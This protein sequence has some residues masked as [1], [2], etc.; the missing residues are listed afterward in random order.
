MGKSFTVD[1]ILAR[2]DGIYAGIK[3]QSG[4]GLPWPRDAFAAAIE[5]CGPKQIALWEREYR[6]RVGTI[7]DYAVTQEA[8][9]PRIKPWAWFY[10]QV[11]AGM[12]GD[13]EGGE[14]V[15]D[16][17]AYQLRPAVV[18]FDP[19]QLPS[20]IDG[21]NLDQG[22][23]GVLVAQLRDAGALRA[24]DNMPLDVPVQIPGEEWEKT[25]L[26]ALSR[27]DSFSG[28]S[29]RLERAIECNFLCQAHPK[30]PRARDRDQ[31]A[32]GALAYFQD[33]YN[34]KLGGHWWRL[35]GRAHGGARLDYVS[36]YDTLNTY[37][38][39]V[40]RPLGVLATG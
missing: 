10:E 35:A 30:L 37:N 12:I 27:L 20:L 16:R 25:L 13:L 6:L 19:R 34:R 4:V 5:K 21:W 2:E 36:Q 40:L 26:P 23:L 38:H 33:F 28:V 32:F 17:A 24:W 1:A 31:S 22:L 3:E 39:L 11:A 18:L 14:F 15:A 8:P 7:P 9:F 29:W